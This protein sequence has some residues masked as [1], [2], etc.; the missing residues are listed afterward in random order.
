MCPKHVFAELCFLNK[1]GGSLLKY[2]VV[3]KVYID[4]VD[5]VVSVF[6]DNV[7][8]YKKSQ[9]FFPVHFQVEFFLY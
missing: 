6:A 7:V 3:N 5:N 8:R 2:T 4:Q 9:T 1:G